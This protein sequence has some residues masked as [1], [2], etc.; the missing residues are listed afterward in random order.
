LELEEGEYRIRVLVRYQENGGLFLSTIPVSMGVE[1][2]GA[3][4]FLAPLFFS[5]ADGWLV[6]RD[7]ASLGVGSAEALPFHIGGLSF[8]PTVRPT[9]GRDE[10]IGV[11]LLGS[12]LS[13]PDLVIA[14]RVL[15]TAGEVASGG[16]LDVMERLVDDPD[17]LDRV[18]GTF[19]P[20]GLTA[21]EYRLEITAALESGEILASN[22][23][24]F[25]VQN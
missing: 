6:V 2:G 11:F 18:V 22:T 7:T 9:L 14:S 24:A 13:Q 16:A 5:L 19:R 3:P 10:A 21:G 25:V 15:T 17:G 4:T 12:D 1:D 23:S 20:S 8:V